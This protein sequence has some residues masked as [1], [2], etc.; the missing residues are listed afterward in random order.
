MSVR[1]VAPV[2]LLAIG[3]VAYADAGDAVAGKAYFMQTCTQCHSAEPGDGG[4]EIGPALTGLFGR[5]AGQG[6]EKFVYS[7]ALK[8]S[9]LVWNAETLDR[10]LEDPASTVPGTTMPLPVPE[11]K[12]RDNVIAF[13]QSLLGAAK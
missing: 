13:F 6:D 5:I 3:Q 7:K 10:F 9:G 2:I 11:K 12:D 4:G 1:M 8:D